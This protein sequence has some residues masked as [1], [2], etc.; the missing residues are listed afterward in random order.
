M[1]G[2]LL[3]H[4][5]INII[6]GASL[7][8]L[9][10]SILAVA[11]IIILMM[12]SGVIFF[13]RLSAIAARIESNIEQ[14]SKGQLNQNVRRTDIKLFDHITTKINDFLY[15]IR[16]LIASFGD[17]SKRI[18]KDACD[19]ESQSQTIKHSAGEI[20]STIQSIAE[21][22]GSQAV[23]TRNMMDMIQKFARGVEDINGNAEKSFSVAKETKDTIEESF[24]KFT[25]IKYKIQ[26][27]KEYNKKVLTALDSLDE[28]IRAIDTITEVVEGIAAQTQ[29][30]ALN[31]AIEAARAGDAGRGFAVVAGEV[32]KLADDSS[33]SA[34]EIE[35]L[36]DG[37]TKQISELSIHIKEEADAVD[38]N[39]EYATDVLKK[40]DVIN[41]TLTSNMQAAK[42]IKMLTK[43]QLE[44]I[45]SIEKEIENINDTTQQ[46]AAVSEEISASTQEQLATIEA[47]HG[48]IVKLLER[49]KESNAIVDNFMSGFKIT[50]VIREKISKTQELINEIVNKRNLL[51]MDQQT[52]EKYLKDQ[53]KKL[54]YIELIVTMDSRGYVTAST[55]ELAESVKDCSAKSYYLNASQGKTYISEEYIS[56]A[57]NN[58]NISVAVPVMSDG[59]FKGIVM[60]D[61]NINEN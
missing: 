35:Q 17:V 51:S 47:V 44:S 61:I 55:V 2:L 5:I 11:A 42:K 6:L 18:M 33:Q 58:Y 59:V 15:K 56:L 22:V 13:I 37:I 14:I 30:L 1:A 53:Q 9:R 43:E 40:S 36:V 16:G 50:D 20:A 49:L 48:H 60:A 46:S 29:L 4:I 10:D 7:F 8:M 34:K 39:L 24:S 25:D 12:A 52:V 3:A 21:S 45:V 27:S 41:D 32:G 26:E 54:E 31:A 19:I 57:S 38:K 23:Y 28:K